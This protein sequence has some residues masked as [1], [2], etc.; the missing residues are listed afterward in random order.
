MKRLSVTHE[1]YIMR[2][3]DRLE[4]E[5]SSVGLLLIEDVEKDDRMYFDMHKRYSS[6]LQ[7]R[8]SMQEDIVKRS[9]GKIMDIIDIES[10]VKKIVAFFQ[11]RMRV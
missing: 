3:L 1:L 5:L 8:L 9:G 7:K 2:C 11:L 6:L 4:K 10:A